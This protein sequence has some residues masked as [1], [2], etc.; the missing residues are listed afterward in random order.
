MDS[1]ESGPNNQGEALESPLDYVNQF[2]AFCDGVIREFL[3]APDARVPADYLVNLVSYTRSV[4][5]RLT[6]NAHGSQVEGRPI[7]TLV[8]DHP[9]SVTTHE[10]TIQANAAVSTSEN[11][12]ILSNLEILGRNFVDDSADFDTDHDDLMS[13]DESDNGDNDYEVDQ[14]EINDLKIKVD[15]KVN[16]VWNDILDNENQFPGLQ[17]PLPATV[18]QPSRHAAL[19][20][21]QSSEVTNMQKPENPVEHGDIK[22]EPDSGSNKKRSVPRAQEPPISIPATTFTIRWR[23][24]SSPFKS[25]QKVYIGSIPMGSRTHF[26]SRVMVSIK[27]AILAIHSPML[28]SLAITALDVN[29]GTGDVRVHTRSELDRDLLLQTS[30][31]WL[32]YLNRGHL[33]QVWYSQ[34]SEEVQHIGEAQNT[35]QSDSAQRVL[36]PAIE[37]DL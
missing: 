34:S 28:D 27:T 22:S 19:N 2:H 31:S 11:L 13:T 25:W 26:L 35:D 9:P 32:P 15:E 14:E 33:A 5:D 30:G 16:L 8:D 6:D 7:K 3:R 20:T 12:N 37:F 1:Q 36:G 21:A 18:S 10:H 4:V 24:S 23:N 17:N 29:A